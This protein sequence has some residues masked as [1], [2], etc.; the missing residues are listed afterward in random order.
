MSNL[1]N[2]PIVTRPNRSFQIDQT[3]S[4]SPHLEEAFSPAALFQDSLSH[5]PQTPIGSA[6]P[7]PRPPVVHFFICDYGNTKVKTYSEKFIDLLKNNGIN[8]FVEK[9]MTNQPGYQVRA[10]SLNTK[11]DFFFQ[12]H[13]KSAG[14]GHVRLYLNGEPNRMS[15]PEAIA[16]IWSWW[17]AQCGTLSRE[18]VG[19]LSANK[20]LAC[21][22]HFTNINLQMLAIDDIQVNLRKAISS[23]SSGSSNIQDCIDRLQMW[24]GTLQDGRQNILKTRVA[25]SDWSKPK[26]VVLTHIIPLPID[27]GISTPLRN[28]LIKII[29]QTLSKIHS[30]LTIAENHIKDSQVEVSHEIPID[31]EPNQYDGSSWKIMTESLDDDI[32]SFQHIASYGDTQQI[33]NSQKMTPII[34]FDYF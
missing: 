21:L 27:S 7:P 5:N 16:S 8:V 24:E 18:E 14:P 13:S 11:A 30:L 22:N 28:I 17:R 10:A 20:L 9:Y 2:G 26:G 25:L 33:I 4:P 6:A 31:E 15:M 19:T 12:I 34:A 32:R 23:P 3:K 1:H 29:D